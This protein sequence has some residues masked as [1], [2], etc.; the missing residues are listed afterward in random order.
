MTSQGRQPD[1]KRRTIEPNDTYFQLG[2]EDELDKKLVAR[3]NSRN[4]VL[5]LNARPSDE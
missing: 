1:C 5:A 3:P 2:G 4:I